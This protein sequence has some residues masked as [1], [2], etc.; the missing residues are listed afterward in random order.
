MNLIIID[1]ELIFLLLDMPVNDESENK[2]STIK[3]E[4]SINK[5]IVKISARNTMGFSIFL[6]AIKAESKTVTI[7]KSLFIE[8]KPSLK[9]AVFTKENTK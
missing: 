3:Q 8:I 2:N 5:E 1:D 6:K 7:E 9:L 4:H